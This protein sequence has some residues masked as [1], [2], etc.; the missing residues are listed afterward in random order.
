[1]NRNRLAL[2]SGV[3]V[4]ASLAGLQSTA[5]AGNRTCLRFLGGCT[6]QSCPSLCDDAT[7]GYHPTQWNQ[8]PVSTA[9]EKPKPKDGM[10]QAKP[11]ET[12]QAIPAVEPSKEGRLR[13]LPAIRERLSK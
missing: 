4:V 13:I 5:Q 8:W 10:T 7:F 2:F 1:M 6:F 11:E 12:L 3:L 9:P